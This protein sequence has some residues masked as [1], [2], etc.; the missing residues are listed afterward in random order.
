V[1]VTATDTQKIA[2]TSATAASTGSD[3]NG[4]AAL[5]AARQVRE[6]LA[7][8]AAAQWGGDAATCASQRGLVRVGT[9]SLP[10]AQV[11]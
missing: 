7:A 8:F 3:L 5:D 4:K 2:N 6:R 9:Q 1:R 10:F 11:W